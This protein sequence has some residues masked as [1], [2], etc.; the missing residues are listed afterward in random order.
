MVVNHSEDWRQTLGFH[1]FCSEAA[2]HASWDTPPCYFKGLEEHPRLKVFYCILG[3][4]EE[5]LFVFSKP[6]LRLNCFL[7]DVARPLAC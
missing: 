3:A 1:T 2:A 6:Q 5:L 7:E 4:L